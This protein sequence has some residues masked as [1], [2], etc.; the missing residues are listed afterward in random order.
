MKVIM[1]HEEIILEHSVI[2]ME[3][4]WMKKRK[5]V[6]LLTVHLALTSLYYSTLISKLF[7]NGFS[8]FRSQAY[9]LL[10]ISQN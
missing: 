10:E 3:D 5:Y 4:G 7:S 1:W 2:E 8:V 9:I 6:Q